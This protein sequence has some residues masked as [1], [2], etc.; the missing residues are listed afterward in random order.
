MEYVFY[1]DESFHDR[2]IVIAEDGT[3]NTLRQNAIDDYVGVFWGCKRANLDKYAEELT[4]F[5]SH[6]RTVFGL[7][8]DKELKSEIIKLKNYQY[9]I[10]SLNKNAMDFY[11][12][13]F[14][15]L[16]HWEFIMQINIVSKVEI[17]VRSALQSIIF[18]FF[19][20]RNSFI[21][22]LTKLIVVHRP[23]QLLEALE[24]AANGGD[25][26]EFR[27]TLLETLRA[28]NEASEGVARKEKSIEAFTEMCYIVEA[29]SFNITPSVKTDFFYSI[30]FDGLSRLLNELSIRSKN[31]KITIDM[32]A[33]TFKAAQEYKF[34]RVKQR[35]SD[36]SIQ[37]RLADLL[38]GFIGRMIYA[39]THDESTR[40]I[41]LEDYSTI[42]LEDIKKKRL[43]NPKWF[44]LTERH[45]DLYKLIYQ[46][47]IE[48][49]S[50]YWTTLTLA[51]NDDALCFYALLRHVA[52]YPTYQ[53]FIAVPAE[54]HSEYYN[55]RAVD[56]LAEYYQSL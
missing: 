46:V 39:M 35:K 24:V 56:E 31:V 16:A 4:T 54:L 10:R 33:S 9:G 30:N 40:E 43:L 12:D 50:H 36:C 25:P 51:Y 37:L 23:K 52:N 45:F 21:Y 38:S 34:G 20:N 48:Q 22:S 44:E 19:A 13:L 32:E 28:L 5:E 41:V 55:S 2:K 26:Q 3:I 29:M 53:D 14:E 17:L 27:N 15:M 1:F 42:D 6:Y 8:A 7:P 11:F 18:P 47:L 49:H